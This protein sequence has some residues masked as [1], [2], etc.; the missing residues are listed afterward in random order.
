MTDLD[1]ALARFRPVDCPDI[2]TS[3]LA[4]RLELLCAGM[5]AR[6]LA[7]VWLDAS[8]SLRYFT[9]LGLYQSERLHGALVK[10]DGTLLY[11]SPEFERPKL[12]LSIRIPAPIVVWEEDEDPIELVA[13]LAYGP[14]ALDPDTPFRVADRLMAVPGAQVRSAGDLIEAQRRIKSPAEIAMLQSAMNASYEVQKALHGGLR[15]GMAASE[16]ASFIAAAHSAKGLEPV[17]AAVQFAEA[18][19]FP[20]PPPG[21]QRLA[22]GDMVLIDLGGAIHGYHSDMTRSYVFGTPTER[23]RQ[24][25]NCEREAQE[26]AFNAARIG[27][28]CALV[29]AAARAVLTEHGFGPGYNLPGLPHR[30]G[31]GLGLDLHEA[32]WIVKDSQVCLLPGMCFSIEPMLCVPGECGIRLEDI[33]VMTKTGPQW[34]C[35]PSRSL[36]QPF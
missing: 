9:G 10:A 31:H 1:A 33:V 24:L 8:S 22:R 11:V 17:F 29:D 30:T 12:L 21:D 3:E 25:W 14:L 28:H 2:A 35:P 4:A 13:S 27:A 7:A 34:F 6:G 5:R 23:Q 16:V 26:A 36:D 19:A 32:P 15:S 20:H 18:T